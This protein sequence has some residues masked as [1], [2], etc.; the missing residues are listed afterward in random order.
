ML[1]QYLGKE[2]HISEQSVE[3]YKKSVE[4]IY[5]VSAQ[6]VAEVVCFS[7]KERSGRSAAVL[8]FCFNRAIKN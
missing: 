8:I 6:L 1:L 4:H 7:S 3:L 2:D 5:N